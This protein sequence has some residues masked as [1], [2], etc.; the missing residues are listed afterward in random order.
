M[1]LDEALAQEP[2]PTARLYTWTL[3]GISLGLKQPRPAWVS[4]PPWIRSGCELVERPTG[5]GIAFHGSD[6]SVAV[7]VPRA[8]PV[9]LRQLMAA[10]CGSAVS[11]CRSYGVH[12]D[13]AADARGASRIT[14]CL[15]DVSPYAVMV[16]GRKV[17]GFA[18][19]R[20]PDTWLIQGSLLAASLPEPLRRAMPDEVAGRLSRRSIT[21]ADAAGRA[22]R[23]AEAAQRWADG[24]AGWW[25]ERLRDAVMRTRDAM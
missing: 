10:V 17:A 9:T 6:V 23:P 25:E 1:T 15:V 4:A 2:V 12:A 18:L 22:I 5:G 21:L 19:R 13:A 16:D 8:V 14:L 3:P 11:F 20:Y 24:W 7:V